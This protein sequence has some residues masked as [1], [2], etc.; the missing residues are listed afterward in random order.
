MA[1]IWEEQR[2][3]VVCLQDPEEAA[4]P[5]LYVQTGTSGMGV[6]TPPVYRCARGTTG[7]ES[8]H[9]HLC[10]FIPGE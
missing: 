4:C 8:Y 2:R 5:P 10:R 3:L 7:L 1:F 6:V 9:L